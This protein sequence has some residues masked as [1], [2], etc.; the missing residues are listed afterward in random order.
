MDKDY[1]SRLDLMEHWY[2]D[3][4]RSEDREQVLL[5]DFSPHAAYLATLRGSVIDIGGGAGLPAR[6]LRPDLNYVVVD[7]S[8]I[9]TSPEWT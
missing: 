8:R 5:R 3:F 1:C 9:W 4:L 2:G 6:F 7:P